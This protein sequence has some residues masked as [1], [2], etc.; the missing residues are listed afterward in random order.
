MAGRLRRTVGVLVAVLAVELIGGAVALWLVADKPL[1]AGIL[2]GVLLSDTGLFLGLALVHHERAA[3]Y[4]ELS[5]D[6]GRGRAAWRTHLVADARAS[7]VA[8]MS[9]V[10]LV[11]LGILMLALGIVRSFPLQIVIGGFCLGVGGVGLLL[12]PRRRRRARRELAAF[13]D[14]F[15]SERAA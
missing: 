9:S 10:L 6:W 14:L 12:H 2:A 3:R 8:W 7:F 5:S 13:E 15:P 4:E 11:G 1:V